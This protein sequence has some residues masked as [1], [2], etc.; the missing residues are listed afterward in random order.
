MSSSG[1]AAP[2]RK[3]ILVLFDVDG[4]LTPSR[5]AVTPAT[6]AFLAELRGRVTTGMVGGS[7]LPK[8]LEQLGEGVLHMFDYVF[9][10][11]GLKAFKDGALIG[12]TSFL[13]KL[14][15]ARLQALVNFVLGYLSTLDIPKKR[16]T[17]IE[18][19][20]GMLNVSPI[21]RNCSQAERDE[22]E[23]YDAA[24]KVRATMIAALQAKF[25]DYNL[26][27][28]IGGQI[29]FDVF[30]VVREGAARARACSP[31]AA[32]TLCSTL[33]RNHRARAPPGRRAGTRPSA[34]STWRRQGLTR[35]TSLGTRRLRAATTMRSLCRR[36]SRATLSPAPRTLRRSAAS[37]LWP[38]RL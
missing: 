35:S 7:D 28:S 18:F 21:G 12:Q 4:T 29:S 17:F 24:H 11:N 25:P 3:N 22:F 31:R 36:W 9:P 2:A 10:E 5:K 27:Y 20:T 16:G 8:Q 26:K 23:A 32:L 6:T 19:R 33:T 15:E 38:R 34:S 37:S 1:A 13:D 30:P 14:G